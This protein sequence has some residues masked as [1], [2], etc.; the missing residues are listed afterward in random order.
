MPIKARENLI[1]AWAFLIGVVLAV[2]VGVF[3]GSNINPVILGILALL[4]V[5]VGYFVSEKDI[6]TFLLAAVSLVIVSFAGIQG[7]VLSAAVLGVDIGRIISSI[8]GALLVLFVP[9]TIIVA[10]KV[11]FS[12]SKS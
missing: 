2:V 9:A 12:I 4:G 5:V 10:L 8:L 1:G 6:Q 11:V 3:A 7:L